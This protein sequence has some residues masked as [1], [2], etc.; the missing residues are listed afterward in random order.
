MSLYEGLDFTIVKDMIANYCSFSLSKTTIE[1]Q[2]PVFDY[3]YIT[4]ELTRGGEALR[5][6]KNHGSPIFAGIHDF[7]DLFK[8]LKKGRNL[9]ASDLSEI[10][11]FMGAYVAM[12]RYRESIE[13]KAEMVFDLIESLTSHEPIRKTIESKINANHEVKDQASPTLASLRHSIRT[14]E[15]DINKKT[16]ELMIRYSDMMMDQITAT[17]N[18]RTT[19]LVK[20]SDKHKVRGFIH[21]ES[22]SGQAVYIEPEELLILNNR[23]QSLKANEKQEV[24]RILQ[25]LTQLVYPHAD[26]LLANLETYTLLDILFAK[27]KWADH[28]DACYATLLEDCNYLY[29]KDARHP[30]ID[31][32]VVVSNTYE[33]KSPYHHLLISGSNTGGKT[34][35][36][37]TIGLFTLMTLSGFP[38]ACSEA[39]IPCFDAIYVDVGDAQSIVESLSTFSAHLSKLSVILKEAT[40]HS[41][42]LLDELGSGTD[43]KEGEYLA[44]AVLD[45]LKVNQIMSVATTHYSNVKEYAKAQDEIL[46]SSVG[47]D[48]DKMLP[49]YRYM[50]GFS[51]NSNALE[52]A[53]RYHI[54]DSII[55][56]ARQLRDAN[57]T[58]QEKLLMVLEQEKVE[59]DQAQEALKQAYQT[60]H[61][62]QAQLQMKQKQFDHDVERQK[63]KAQQAADQILDEAM[64][65]A[66]EVIQEL[67]SMKQVKEHEIIASVGKLKPKIQEPEITQEESFALHDY[68]KVKGLQYQGVIVSIKGNRVTIETNGMKMNLKKHEITHAVRPK[69]K[70]QASVSSKSLST[71]PSMECNIIGMRVVEG[72]EVVNKYL[73]NAMYH[74]LYTVTIIHG[75]GTGALRTAVHEYLKKNK[76]V[77]SYRLGGEYEGGLGATVVT[78][79][80]NKNG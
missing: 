20:A 63:Q 11:T 66:S 42:V 79:R 75:S 31:Q 53:K 60:L 72:L 76:N 16:T 67:R 2:E 30:L 47:F 34:V 73:D 18:N 80:G 49:T 26:E 10:A 51:G 23:L 12:K 25:E 56:H 71:R 37:K 39:V 27:A 41:L 29:L 1:T 68:V 24:E 3:L 32:N 55:E 21:D 38:I 59:L 58:K 35:T 4:R 64:Q 8:Q 17:R 69:V 74:K 13:I 15:S 14:C 40:S 78:L 52:I 19:L 57:Y 6:F 48:L 7:R 22:A 46:L 43:P 33:I 44:I 28:F 77:E 65:Q 45:Y 54:K 5:L 62:E 70:K 50:S 36:L 9:A 61:S